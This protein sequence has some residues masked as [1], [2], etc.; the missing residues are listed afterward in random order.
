MHDDGADG[1]EETL[2]L[3]DVLAGIESGDVAEMFACGTAA[4][5]T[6]IGSLSGKDFRVEIPRN[7]VTRTIYDRIT[8][9]QLGKVEDRHGWL[10]RL[11]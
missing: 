5:I 3:A 2:A 11:A 6:S 8:G 9:I 1:R 4:V 7:E 10:Y